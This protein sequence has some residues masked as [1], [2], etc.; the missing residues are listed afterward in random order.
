MP[1]RLAEAFAA[2]N[3]AGVVATLADNVTLRVAVHDQP[4]EGLAAAG[5][6]L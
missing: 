6:I 4:L 5:Q 2:E 1:K 3:A